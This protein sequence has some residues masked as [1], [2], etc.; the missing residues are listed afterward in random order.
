MPGGTVDLDGGDPVG[1][2]NTVTLNADATINAGTRPAFSGPLLGGADTLVLNDSLTSDIVSLTVNLTDP[3]AEWTLTADGVL[4][5]N[6]LGGMLGG[7]GI[8]GSDFNMAGTA[9]I[10]GNE[11]LDKVTRTFPAL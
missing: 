9:T 5:I 3:N 7:G 4:D 2:G 8:Q 1:F 11:S 10:S 6:S